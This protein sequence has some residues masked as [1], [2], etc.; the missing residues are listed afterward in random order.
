MY[1]QEQE[2]ATGI[3]GTGVYR[4]C[5]PKQY[6]YVYRQDFIAV[7]RGNTATKIKQSAYDLAISVRQV[8]C[9]NRFY[10]RFINATL[11]RDGPQVKV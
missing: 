1:F 5:F 2:V 6:G 8:S 7:L 3:Q 4:C 10:T 11:A 9:R